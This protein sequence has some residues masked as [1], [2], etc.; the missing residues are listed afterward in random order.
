MEML[1]IIEAR[2]AKWMAYSY[3]CMNADFGLPR[4]RTFWIWAGIAGMIV[5]AGIVA[6][7]ARQIFNG[8]ESDRQETE[9]SAE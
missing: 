7:V 4:C 8:S 9:N 1:R 3:Y 2:I 6:Y 5:V